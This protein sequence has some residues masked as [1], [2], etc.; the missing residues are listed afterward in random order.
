LV[1]PDTIVRWH[2][3]LVRRRWAY[4]DRT[5]RP[6]PAATTAIIVNGWLHTGDVGSIDPDGHVRV[7]DRIKDM[8]I[9]GGENISPSRLRPRRRR[10]RRSP[11]S[12]SSDH[13]A[14]RAGR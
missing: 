12:P 11:T 1:T 10:T 13:G 5:G 4:P 6:N 9:R 7:L 14:A 3:R 8:I 2:R